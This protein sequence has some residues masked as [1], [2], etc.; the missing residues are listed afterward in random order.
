M[1]KRNPLSRIFGVGSTASTI[2]GWVPTPWQAAV[3]TGI[4]AVTAYLGL[5]EVP[6]AEAIFFAAGVMAFLMA[7]IF[8]Y[9]RIT[10]MTGVFRR[11]T[12]PGVG[13]SG[14]SLSEDKLMLHHVN[15]FLTLHNASQR[16]MF[17]RLKRAS[18][19]L[20]RQVPAD[21]AVDH[22]VVILQ[23]N[24]GVQ[25]N[26]ATIERVP[27]PPR[28]DP[29]TEGPKG[30]V[31]LDV[32]Y[33]PSPDELDYILHYKADIQMALTLD[34]KTDTASITI[35]SALKELTHSNNYS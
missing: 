35:G 1:P 19:S 7:V 20:G 31:E 25:I 2:W 18:P 26:M 16:L 11:L 28:K 13:L 9:L 15:L 3:V 8:F 33:G 4:S 21:N 12:V 17:Y 14:V 22:A 27:L 6:A 5:R 29:I 24:G 30:T 34:A 23:V 10:E 32:E